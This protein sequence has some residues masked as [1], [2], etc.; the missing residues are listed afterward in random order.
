V[1]VPA[2]RRPPMSDL[3]LADFKAAL[4]AVLPSLRAFA[5]S[6]CRNAVEA[7]DLVQETML[8]AWSARESYI[9]ESNFK[10]WA[11]RILRNSLYSNWRK[12]S[13]LTQLDDTVYEK[14]AKATD[15]AET[16]LELAEVS[17]AILDLPL[18]QRE[19]LILI[20][21][22]GFNYEEVAAIAGVAVGT[23]KSRVSR[24]RANLIALME[25]RAHRRPQI[26]ALGAAQGLISDADRLVRSA[27]A[28]G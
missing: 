19:A 13:R 15:N 26:S 22:G 25:N 1:T 6:L 9:E 20:A 12:N 28:S 27:A 14:T 3:R 4:I 23:I 11:F 21:A 18:E 8:K 24:G 2:T 16:A 5:R 7:D 10:A 17:Q